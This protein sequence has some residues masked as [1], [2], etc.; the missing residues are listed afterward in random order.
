MSFPSQ[1]ERRQECVV[2]T[3][4]LVITVV[5]VNDLASVERIVLSG[6]EV[7]AKLPASKPAFCHSPEQYAGSDEAI[8]GELRVIYKVAVIV[9]R[10][11]LRSLLIVVFP[12]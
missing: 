6:V 1:C 8:Q 7:L 2:I 4:Y 10:Q 12:G 11:Y 5:T 3:G 9:E